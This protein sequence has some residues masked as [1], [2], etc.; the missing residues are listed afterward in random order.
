[1]FLLVRGGLIF[2][3]PR[4]ELDGAVNGGFFIGSKVFG[5]FVV[6]L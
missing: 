6:V 2:L 1:M 4:F 3:F 5:Y